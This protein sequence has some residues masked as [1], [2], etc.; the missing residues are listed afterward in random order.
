[1]EELMP[2]LTQPGSRS[3]TLIR[4]KASM[5]FWAAHLLGND[6]RLLLNQASLGKGAGVGH[7]AAQHRV[8]CRQARRAGGGLLVKAL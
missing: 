4:T 8:I 6:V 1:M 2:G 3:L 5:P 7:G